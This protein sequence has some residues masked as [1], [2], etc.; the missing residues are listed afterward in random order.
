MQDDASFYENNGGNSQIFETD[1]EIHSRPPTPK[2]KQRP[3]VPHL[4]LTQSDPAVNSKITL[5]SKKTNVY[6]PPASDR[7]SWWRVTIKVR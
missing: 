7:E 1:F 2:T 3:A 5:R 4:P 6:A